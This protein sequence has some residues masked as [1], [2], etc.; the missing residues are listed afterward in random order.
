MAQQPKQLADYGH[1]ARSLSATLW[2]S[3]EFKQAKKHIKTHLF[4]SALVAFQPPKF[5]AGVCLI[6][7]LERCTCCRL[8]QHAAYH[9]VGVVAS[10][11]LL[12]P[13]V[14]QG[15]SF[16]FANLALACGVHYSVASINLILL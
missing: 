8:H 2:N 12:L 13:A 14:L 1:P 11:M 5:S 16:I 6:A 7:V 3:Y 15:Y 10:K 9:L 4:A